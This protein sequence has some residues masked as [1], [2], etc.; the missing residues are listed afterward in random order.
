MNENIFLRMLY[1]LKVVHSKEEAL[2]SYER[3]PY[4]HSFQGLKSLLSTYGVES[5]AYKFSET[6]IEEIPVPFVAELSGDLFVIESYSES[7]VTVFYNGLIESIKKS[8][9]YKGWDGLTLVITDIIPDN[10]RRQQVLV[11]KLT[12]HI[13][14]LSL[15]L[16][17]I[18]VGNI[19][20]LK[21]LYL[22]LDVTG[23]YL[24]YLTVV[25]N[26]DSMR[27]KFCN[28]MQSSNCD[29]VHNSKLSTFIGRY[30]LGELGIAY[31]LVNIIIQVYFH[32]YNAGLFILNTL[33]LIFSLW[34][35]I[36]QKIIGAWCSICL[37]V[38]AIV[39]L[40]ALLILYNHN[41]HLVSLWST[42]VLF[43]GSIFCIAF[44]LV[45]KYYNLYKSNIKHKKEANSKVRII[46]NLSLFKN[47]SL[48]NK[49]Y[50][51]LDASHIIVGNK[52][53]EHQLTIVMN[54]Y[55]GPCKIMHKK[56]MELANDGILNLCCIQF[57][58]MTFKEDKQNIIQRFI[59][60]F[61]NKGYLQFLE[62]ID[63]WYE[64]NKCNSNDCL[65]DDEQYVIQEMQRQIMWLN[66]Y[67]I[68]KTPLVLY[69]GYTFPDEYD[70]SDIKFLF[71]F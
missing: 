44:Y 31:F 60:D 39:L 6:K 69:N 66:K 4:S 15:V 12:I 37:L 54:P 25:D 64:E 14:I 71:K 59:Q 55:C 42:D 56:L 26:R 13:F 43:I 63:Y 17:I 8:S 67:N 65:L 23:L 62:T 27:E 19:S 61:Y 40:K 68:F 57:V 2:D 33:C 51:T 9:F 45:D 30:T 50:D 32:E 52:D 3:N 70:I 49:Y 47:L 1:L 16:S 28:I 36:Y 20:L 11:E 22:S 34:S 46:S 7:T 18:I 48:V 58:F 10:K 24:S 5:C 21:V 53:S 41:A 38:Q 29:I 35:I